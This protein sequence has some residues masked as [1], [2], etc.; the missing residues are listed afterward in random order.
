MNEGQIKICYKSSDGDIFDTHAEA[1]L[2]ELRLD[3]KKELRTIFK[4]A[5]LVSFDVLLMKSREVSALLSK[6]ADATGRPPL[7]T[8]ERKIE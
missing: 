2:N 5:D 1:Q 7:A 4:T 8:K 3:A 6:Y